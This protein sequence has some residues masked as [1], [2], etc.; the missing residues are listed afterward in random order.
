RGRVVIE[1]YGKLMSGRDVAIAALL[2]AEEFGFATAPLVSMGCM[3]MRVCNK[4]TCPVGI[5][6]QNETLRKRFKGKPEH[7]MNFMTFIAEELREIMARLGFRSI[8]EMAGRSDY[9]KIK[10]KQITKRAEMVDLSRLIDSS[11][12]EAE[13]RHFYPEQ[14][15]DFGLDKGIDERIFLPQFEKWGGKESLR[16]DGIPVSSTDRTVGTILGS[17]ITEKFGNGLPEDSVVITLSG[18]GGQSFGAFIPKGLTLCLKGDANDGFGKGLSGGKLV[19]TPPENAAYEASENVIVGNV[20]LYG[21]TS[22]TAYISGIAG[23]R[24]MVRNSGAAAVCEGCGDHGL[25]Y[26]TGGIAVI[27]GE[28][29][30]NFAA[31]MSGGI[32]YVLDMKHNLYTKTNRSLIEMSEVEE[33]AD[34]KELQEILLEYEKHTG[35]E[36]ASR[37]LK[38]YKTYVPYFK[39]IIPV[40]YHGM[41]MKIGKYEEQGIRHE[42]AVYEAFK[43]V[44]DGRNHAV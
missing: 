30:D 24:F 1:T 38:D 14:A 20:A 27:L 35:S 10:E 17:C 9:L 43:D 36:K 34:R 42:Q 44:A 33:E 6:C 11:Y 5:A 12:A 19:L 21:A 39:K 18:G 13:Q 40:E 7:V 26:M 32:A 41:L 16:I 28:V 23:E 25:E 29:G 31:G 2:G 22:G 15:F 3:M 37:I 4:D 8:S